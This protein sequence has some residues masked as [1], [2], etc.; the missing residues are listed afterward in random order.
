VFGPWPPR[1]D[2]R[3]LLT[4]ALP[5][6]PCGHLEA[7]PCGAERLPACMLAL[8]VTDVLKAVET[9]VCQG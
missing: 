3:V 5:C 7:P 2:Q 9:L 4:N 1:P 8:G 6:V